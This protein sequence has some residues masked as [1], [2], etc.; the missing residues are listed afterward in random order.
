MQA[1]A[2]HRVPSVHATGGG[3]TWIE[4]PTPLTRSRRQLVHPHAGADALGDGAQMPVVRQVDHLADPGHL[5]EQAAGLL[6]AEVVEGF[7]D[8]VGDE[9]HRP[10]R[11]RET[12]S[13]E[14]TYEL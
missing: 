9:G 5:R 10:A 2:S 3:A 7:H 8:V 4:P 12:R 6:G 11:L 1:P 13:E 14:H